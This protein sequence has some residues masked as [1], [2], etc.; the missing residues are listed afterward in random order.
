MIDGLE[1]NSMNPIDERVVWFVLGLVSGALSSGLLLGLQ[2][3]KGTG[4]RHAE[5][6]CAAP[7]LAAAPPIE[8]EAL[9]EQH[10]AVASS[11]LI[12]VSAARAAGFNLK[13]ADD[14]T[15][16]E[17]IGP[18][19]EDLLRA[20]GIDSFVKVACLGVDDL[21]DILERGG[22]SF[23]LA[24]P[25]SWAQLAS[26]AAQNRWTEL[27]QLQREMVGRMMPSSDA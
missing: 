18:K 8:A 17:G 10:A 5:P 26:L 24:N 9:P 19:I 14:L 1:D 4:A 16:L 11:R 21:L 27:K 22:P 6:P 20:N 7:V 2:R 12:D 3:R 13:H 15:I 23:R 25:E